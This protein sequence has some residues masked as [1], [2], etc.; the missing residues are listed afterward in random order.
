MTV[1]KFDQDKLDVTLCPTDLIRAVS[2]VMTMGAKKY[3][4]DNWR[5]GKDD[6]EFHRRVLAAA[7]RHLY[8]HTEGII[9]DAESGLPHIWHAACNLGF[10]IYYM[11]QN[12]KKEL[13]L[14]AV[15]KQQFLTGE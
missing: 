8:S 11:N 13:D 10:L 12:I 7:M 1:K 14:E 2:E 9:N 4:R 6:P 5:L 15:L 3:G